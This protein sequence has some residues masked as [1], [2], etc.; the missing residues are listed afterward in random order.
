MSPDAELGDEGLE[1]T[2]RWGVFGSVL[3]AASF[4]VRSGVF[5][6]SGACDSWD[7]MGNVEEVETID[8]EEVSSASSVSVLHSENRLCSATKREFVKL[9]SHAGEVAMKH[10]CV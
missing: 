1:C 4:D 9:C 7:W 6:S 10:C 3:V 2:V 5:H 8:L